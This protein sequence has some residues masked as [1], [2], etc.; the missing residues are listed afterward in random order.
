MEL[1]GKDLKSCLENEIVATDLVR[2]QSVK[3]FHQLLCGLD[4]IHSQNLIHRALKPSNIFV[5]MN[6]FE[7]NV[8]IGD[9]GY[10][11]Y[12]DDPLASYVGRP[13]YQAPEQLTL[14]D[15]YDN[16]VDMYALGIVIFEVRKKKFDVNEDAWIMCLKNLCKRTMHTLKEFEPYE[17]PVWEQIFAA[18]LASEPCH[19]PNAKDVLHEFIPVLGEIKSQQIEAP[20]SSL[21]EN[22]ALHESGMLYLTRLP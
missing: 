16:K 17:P 1:C 10:A 6:G 7:I 3:I 22:A 15:T 2:P 21:M 19:R 4:Y 11:S 13:L 8:K 14:W 18:L 20:V 5:D 9:F 12:V